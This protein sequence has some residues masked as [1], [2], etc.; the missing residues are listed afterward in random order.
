MNQDK[1]STCHF[2]EGLQSGP[3][4]VS[5]FCHER[6]PVWTGYCFA[7]PRGGGK[8]WC[9]KHKQDERRYPRLSPLPDRT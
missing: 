7:W 3:G 6:P 1:C 2:F 8:D 4:T 9:G 5:G